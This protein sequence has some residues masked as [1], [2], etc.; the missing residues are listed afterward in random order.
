M[1][2]N[3][4]QVLICLDIVSQSFK[5]TKY[6]YV[7]LLLWSFNFFFFSFQKSYALM[8]LRTLFQYFGIFIHKNRFANDILFTKISLK[9]VI[10]VFKISVSCLGNLEP[11]ALALQVAKR[12]IILHAFI[13]LCYKNECPEKWGGWGGGGRVVQQQRNNV[14]VV[15]FIVVKN[16]ISSQVTGL[17][18]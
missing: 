15:K 7:P 10:T 4:K 5:R 12:L 17:H 14:V 18:I 2:N 6:S 1:G 16:V 8:I 9:Q 11:K 13:D 3:S